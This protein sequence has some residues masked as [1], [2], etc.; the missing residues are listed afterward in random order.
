MRDQP[1]LESQVEA[2]LQEAQDAVLGISLK[3]NAFVNSLVRPPFE[4]W[5][6]ISRG[7]ALSDLTRGAV[8]Y[9]A[10]ALTLMFAWLFMSTLLSPE[11]RTLIGNYVYY[12]I[13]IAPLLLAV[14][15]APAAASRGAKT[16]SPV[17][18]VAKRALAEGLETDRDLDLVEKG[19]KR[20]EIR[21]GAI[22]TAL[23]WFAGISWGAWLY[24][25]TQAVEA[26]TSSPPLLSGTDTLLALGL[27]VVAAIAVVTQGIAQIVRYAAEEW[28]HI[29]CGHSSIY[30][31]GQCVDRTSMERTWRSEPADL[32][33]LL[34]HPQQ[35]RDPITQRAQREDRR[36]SRGR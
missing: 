36:R 34:R 20:R 26:R 15:R 16:E 14:L 32:R 17:R 27:G 22:V 4:C 8:R 33:Q 18:P 11:T 12:A 28:V 30:G 35:R 31:T 9:A 7:V 25:L 19:I 29:S 6:M 3:N 10:G 23:R 24:L 13:L 21:S 2:L 1:L 5:R